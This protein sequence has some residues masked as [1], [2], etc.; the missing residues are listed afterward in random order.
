MKIFSTI[1]KKSWILRSLPYTIWFNFKTLPFKQAIKLPIVFYKPR[2]FKTSGKIIIEG[3]VRRCMI[4]L[5]NNGVS[6]Y[7]NSGIAFDNKGTIIFKG[8]ALI[9]ND[10]AISVGENGILTIGSDLIS[11]CSLK[12]V[13]Y[14]RVDIA[15]RVTLGWNTFVCDTDFHIATYSDGRQ[16]Q[17]YG[18]ITIGHDTWIANNCKLYK[19]V[20]IPPCCVVGADT[21]LMKSPDCGE[22]SLI[23]N[24]RSTI[25]KVRGIKYVRENDHIIYSKQQPHEA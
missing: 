6:I 22:N 17:G 20:S 7:P 25:V 24:E 15:D 12:L 2:F 5:G 1:K 23:C 4:R 18:Q 19:N 9:G 10:S 3:D 13:C 8:K 21:I 14:N 11:T 16:P